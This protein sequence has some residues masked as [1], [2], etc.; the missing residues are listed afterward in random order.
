[1]SDPND[2]RAYSGAEAAPQAIDDRR[3]IGRASGTI[4]RGWWRR[5]E[6]HLHP[7]VMDRDA[8]SGEEVNPRRITM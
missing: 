3:K 7:L 8:G 1:L 5:R 2:E 6:P 4:M